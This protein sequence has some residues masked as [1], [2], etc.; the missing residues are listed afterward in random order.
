MATW[1]R[2]SW[3]EHNDVNG[4]WTCIPQKRGLLNAINDQKPRLCLR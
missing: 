3:S 4:R 1:Q 2:K